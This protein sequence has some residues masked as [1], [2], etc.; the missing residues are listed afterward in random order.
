MKMC[1]CV[2]IM[3]YCSFD[4]ESAHTNTSSPSG[5]QEVGNWS[6]L[7]I[8]FILFTEVIV[9]KQNSCKLLIK[10]GLDSPSHLHTQTLT[11]TWQQPQ[12][13]RVVPSLITDIWTNFHW[14]RHRT[15]SRW[16]SV[17]PVP[18][19]R[20]HVHNA[21]G[22]FLAIFQFTVHLTPG[23]PHAEARSHDVLTHGALWRTR[24]PVNALLTVFHNYQS[25][26]CIAH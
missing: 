18:R 13:D 23:A 17:S 4:L 1:L 12:R 8:H 19:N 5:T 24:V 7:Q 25:I 3:L 2:I 15:G 10:Q 11:N 22:V 21:G 26:T 14:E 6:A 9:T 16:V 20:L